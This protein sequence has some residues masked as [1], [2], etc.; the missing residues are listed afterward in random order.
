MPGPVD[1]L[2]GTRRQLPLNEDQASVGFCFSD[3]FLLT[4][5]P[6]SRCL[7]VTGS[8]PAPGIVPATAN[9]RRASV[10]AETSGHASGPAVVIPHDDGS[11]VSLARSCLNRAAS[12]APIGVSRS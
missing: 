10:F 7:G 8:G 5:R 3:G 2:I 12:P 1:F 9:A 4:T 11:A 6:V